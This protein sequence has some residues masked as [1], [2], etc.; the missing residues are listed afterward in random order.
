[1]ALTALLIPLSFPYR[2]VTIPEPAGNSV[3]GDYDIAPKLLTFW[4]ENL[5]SVATS[6]AETRVRH[7]LHSSQR[8]LVNQNIEHTREF[9]AVT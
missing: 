4:G 8:F 7:S 9:A 1:M 5:I 3:F 6:I 2:L